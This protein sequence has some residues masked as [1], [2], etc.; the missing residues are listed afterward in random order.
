MVPVIM[1]RYRHHVPEIV[2]ARTN[3]LYKTGM[4]HETLVYSCYINCI[5]P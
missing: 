1:G 2:H 4:Y 3:E 5:R